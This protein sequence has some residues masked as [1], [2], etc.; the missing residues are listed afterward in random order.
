MSK[1]SVIVPVH[2]TENYLE[3]C[4][5]SLLC[6]TLQDIEIILVE[7]ASTDGSLKKCHECAEKD[8]RISVLSYPIGDLSYARNR[9][10]EAAR[11]EYVAFVDSDDTVDPDMYGDL[12]SFA[13]END[14]D[15]VYSNYVHVYDD[16]VKYV[17]KE[18]GQKRILT[19]QQLLELNLKH[20]VTS[21]ACTMIARRSLFDE[22]RFPEGRYFED[23]AFTFK[24]I[25]ASHKTGYID[26]AY[27]N[28]YQRSGSIFHLNSWKKMHDWLRAD[29]A[30]LEFIAHSDHFSSEKKA[31]LAKKPTYTFFRQLRRMGG[32]AKTQKEKYIISELYNQG[33]YLVPKK[34]K[35]SIKTKIRKLIIKVFYI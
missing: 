28:Y 27:Y 20:E 17:Y 30:R 21:S 5:Q 23:R 2:N 9:G 26:K 14:L 12:Y 4:V 35:T 18:T 32:I 8:S 16:H 19:P 7:N 22:L 31:I 3:K 6:Q 13:V 15:I 24:L 29:I 11:S 33:C 34:C 10:V 25:D 1:I